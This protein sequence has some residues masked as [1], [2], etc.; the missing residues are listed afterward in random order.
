MK[1]VI[2]KYTSPSGKVYIGQTLNE[3]RRRKEFLNPQ[4]TYGGQKIQYA[5]GKYKPE[6]F[7]YCILFE[8]EYDDVSIATKELNELEISYIKEYDSVKNGYNISIGGES[9]RAVMQDEDCKRR[10]IESLKEYNRTHDNAFKGHKH[11]EETKK[12]LSKLAVGRKSGFSGKHWDEKHRKEH[13][14][15]LK[16]K[17]TKEKNPF[18]GK[19]HSKDTL[20]RIVETKSKNIAQIDVNTNK[21]IQIYKSLSQAARCVA[22]IKDPTIISKVCRGYISP[23]TGKEYTTAYGYKW[24]F[25]DSIEGS[26]TTEKTLKM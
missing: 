10:M 23:K 4:K 6:N 8:K 26:T 12:I 9:I 7:D 16:G 2:Y 21:I 25:V 20:N 15:A 17:F 5:R 18:Y 19:K 24:K 22:N 1:G 11:T 3:E 14:E 13:S